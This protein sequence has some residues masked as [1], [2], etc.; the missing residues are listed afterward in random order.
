MVFTVFR[1]QSS[2][3]FSEVNVKHTFTSH[4][5]KQIFLTFFLASLS[6]YIFTTFSLYE[7]ASF[8][9]VLYNSNNS[10][11]FLARENNKSKTYLQ[12]MHGRSAM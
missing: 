4:I 9:I 3:I 12:L 2:T 5:D 1:L 8:I 10:A 11:M 7:N 6:L